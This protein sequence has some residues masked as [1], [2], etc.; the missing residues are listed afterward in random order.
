MI[1]DDHYIPRCLE[2]GIRSDF[3][4]M[5]ERWGFLTSVVLLLPHSFMISTV[6]KS[7]SFVKRIVKSASCHEQRWA[8][9]GIGIAMH[10]H[11]VMRLS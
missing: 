11:A 8:N 4:L 3:V 10:S 1:I 2:L 9:G 7:T 5:K 6:T